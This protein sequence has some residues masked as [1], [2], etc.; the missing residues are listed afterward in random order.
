[1][2]KKQII[3]MDG[4]HKENKLKK[5]KKSILV[6][7]NESQNNKVFNQIIPLPFKLLLVI[8]PYFTDMSLIIQPAYYFSIM[9]LLISNLGRLLLLS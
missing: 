5:N 3:I 6:G 4:I 7:K 1:M 8:I 2:G 9:F